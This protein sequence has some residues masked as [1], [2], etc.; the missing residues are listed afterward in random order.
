M[1]VRR[2]VGLL[3]ALAIATSG[4]AGGGTVAQVANSAWSP[5]GQPQY[6]GVVRLVAPG[7]TADLTITV[8]HQRAARSEIGCG[9]YLDQDTRAL[10]MDFGIYPQNQHASFPALTVSLTNGH[11]DPMYSVKTTDDVH[12]PC[13][14]V[15][16]L[17][18]RSLAAGEEGTALGAFP[19]LTKT[20]LVAVVRVDGTSVEVPLRPMCSHGESQSVTG[21]VYDPIRWDDQPGFPSITI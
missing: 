18:M 15:V 16:N 10:I 3:L 20:P 1:G 14:P 13:R 5:A 9:R 21:C 17:R 2:R 19:G 6:E 4:C 12:T 11:G 7:N 8:Y